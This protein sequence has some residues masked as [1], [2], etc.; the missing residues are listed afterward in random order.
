[1]VVIRNIPSDISASNLHKKFSRFGDV[2][3]YENAIYMVQASHFIMLTFF[4]EQLMMLF[5]QSGNWR[6]QHA[7][8]IRS[9]LKCMKKE[10]IRKLKTWVTIKL[11]KMNTKH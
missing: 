8:V 5:A 2:I 3:T 9:L 4:S 6:K 1:M 7:I 11:I 10:W